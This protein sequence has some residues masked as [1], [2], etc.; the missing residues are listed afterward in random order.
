MARYIN[1][2]T[3]FGFKKLFGEEGSKNL[4]QD[5]LKHLEDFNDIPE[6]LQEEVF[7]EGFQKAE[8]ANYNQ[9]E[10][11]TY[12]KSL[13]SYRDL[14]GV[15]D[16]AYSDGEKIGIEKGEKKRNKEVVE[17]GIRAGLTDEVIQSL[18]GLSVEE[19]SAIR[20]RIDLA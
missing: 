3:D 7:V 5:F 1:P 13:K 10:R 15:L 20:K 12:E 19:I 9:E 11:D 2:Y 18:T 17:N 16:T 14:K 4:L 6:I 8:I